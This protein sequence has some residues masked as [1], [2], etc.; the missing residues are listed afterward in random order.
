LLL[1]YRDLQRFVV[2]R[3]LGVYAMRLQEVIVFIIELRDRE[4]SAKRLEAADNCA[5]LNIVN[6]EVRLAALILAVLVPDSV[7]VMVSGEFDHVA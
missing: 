7:L 2:L 6:E 3:L 4:G 5:L 1:D